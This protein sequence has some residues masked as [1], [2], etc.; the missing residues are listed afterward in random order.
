MRYKQNGSEEKRGGESSF[1]RLIAQKM[2]TTKNWLKL[3]SLGLDS[4][5]RKA[6]PSR[7]PP[8]EIELGSPS[9]VIQTTPRIHKEKIKPPGNN[10]SRN[11]KKMK[12]LS[13]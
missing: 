6:V 13:C 8:C 10:D 4:P 11:S 12:S 1:P 7:G 9:A 2:K 3:F 5:G